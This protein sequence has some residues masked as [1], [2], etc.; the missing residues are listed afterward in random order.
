VEHRVLR[1]NWQE[2]NRAKV[3][4]LFLFFQKGG[5]EGGAFLDRGERTKRRKKKKCFLETAFSD[6]KGLTVQ[7]CKEGGP[8]QQE[9]GDPRKKKP[10]KIPGW[11]MERDQGAKHQ[12]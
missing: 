8:I 12:A 1:E 2:K 4:S 5:E 6:R 10:R 9:S 7:C 11:S 3:W